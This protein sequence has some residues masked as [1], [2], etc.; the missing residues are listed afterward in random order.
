MMNI[1]VLHF[2]SVGEE[3]ITIERGGRKSGKSHEAERK[4]S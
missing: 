2:L 3:K 1:T 4:N